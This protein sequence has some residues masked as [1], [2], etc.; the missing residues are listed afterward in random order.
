MLLQYV[1]N[2]FLRP[3][4]IQGSR[5]VSVNLKLWLQNEVADTNLKVESTL[6]EL[7]YWLL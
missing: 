7:W 3:V 1:D 5:W 6:G 4:I 2:L